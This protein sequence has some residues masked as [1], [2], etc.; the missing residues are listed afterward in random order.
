ML[1]Y[2][3]KLLD[4]RESFRSIRRINNLDINLKSYFKNYILKIIIK[5]YINNH[6]IFKFFYF[7]NFTK[8]ICELFCRLFVGTL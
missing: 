2:T 7:H 8:A 6:L 3:I 4:I 1:L 5:L